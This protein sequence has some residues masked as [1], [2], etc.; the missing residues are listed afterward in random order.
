MTIPRTVIEQTTDRHLNGSYRG[1]VN[2]VQ[3]LP[4]KGKTGHIHYHVTMFVEAKSVQVDFLPN[5]I[6]KEYT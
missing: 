1:A 6:L 3:I 5:V 4:S 2:L